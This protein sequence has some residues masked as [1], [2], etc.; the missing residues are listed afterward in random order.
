MPPVQ[1]ITLAEM[2]SAGVRGMLVYCS[3]YQCSIARA[4]KPIGFV[5]AP[6]CR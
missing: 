3:D 6:R 2:R 1:K 4:S 5:C